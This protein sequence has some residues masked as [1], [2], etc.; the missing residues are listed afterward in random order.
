MSVTDMK[1]S[2]YIQ[3][4]RLLYSQNNSSKVWDIVKVHESVA[5]ILYHTQRKVMLF[6]R[7][8]RPAVY[9][10]SIPPDERAKID[11]EK[12]PPELGFTLELCA[13]IIE[14][15][16]SAEV[17][18]RQEVMEECGYDVPQEKLERIVSYRCG[19]GISGENQV[20]FYAEVDDSMKISEGG[21]NP[22]EGEMLE[23]VERSPVEMKEFVEQGEQRCPVGLLFAVNWFLNN[24]W[25]QLQ[26]S[27]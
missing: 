18:A 17:I 10:N 20:L 7:Q 22:E 15:G 8:F 14:K 12:Y 1:S 9:Y 24:K 4:L 13:G 25:P 3:P 2:I 6:V 5:I 21:G 11:M 16:L 23:L 26:G 27:L 19:V